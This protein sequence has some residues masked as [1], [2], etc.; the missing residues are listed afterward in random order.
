MRKLFTLPVL[1][2]T[3]LVSLAGTA[4]AG[5]TTPLGSTKVIETAESRT[6]CENPFIEHPFAK[7]GDDRD[8]VLAPGG[9]FDGNVA[10]WQFSGGTQ[11]VRSTKGRSL[12][13][14]KGGSAISPSMCL[15]LHFPTFRVSH[16]VVRKTGLLGGL[17]LPSPDQGL[18]KI[19]IEV[20]YL[21]V[22]NPEWEEMAV[23]DGNH[24]LSTGFSW[25]LSDD[26]DLR[27]DRGGSEPGARQA[28]LRFTVVS[29][30]PKDS[31]RIDDI[32]VDPKRR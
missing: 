18:A 28:A 19:K 27:P 16:D 6:A 24:G 25:R 12:Q 4:H 30:N 13:L 9:S 21:G 31:F 22:P 7:F 2:V 3:A 1:V 15:D 8:Y 10:G 14:P 11:V 17:H 20:V 32:Y 26:V 29:A 5:S 23:F